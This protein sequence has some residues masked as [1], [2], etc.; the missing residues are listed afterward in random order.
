MLALPAL[1][2]LALLPSPAHAEGDATAGKALYQPCIEC[3]GADGG[4]SQAKGAPRL[5]GQRSDYLDRQLRNFQDTIRTSKDMH[6]MADTL[7]GS[8]Q[9][10]DLVAYIGTLQAPTPPETVT[11]DVAAGQ[12]TWALCSQCHGSRGQGV[13]SYDTPRLAGQHDWY[14]KKQLEAFLHGSRG[15]SNSDRYGA[16]MEKAQVALKAPNAIRDV[17]AWINTLE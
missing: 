8:T 7:E 12:A 16:E 6:T 17:V 1:L 13:G 10:R 5:A 15:G 11:G 2:A 14:L 9:L 3:H 4:G